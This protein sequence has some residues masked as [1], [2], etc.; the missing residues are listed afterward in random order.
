MQRRRFQHDLSVDTVQVLADRAARLRAFTLI[1]LLVVLAIIGVLFSLIGVGV[2]S[3]IGTARI[4]ATKGTI[5]KI[6]GLL[7][8]RMDAL[9]VKEPETALIDSLVPRFGNR[10]RAETM[11]R[12]FQFRQAFPQTWNEI[13]RFYPSLLTGHSYPASANRRAS[14]ESAEVLFFILTKANVLGYA[15]E[16]TDVFSSNEI[17]DTDSPPNGAI[18]FVDAWG[19]PLRFYRWPTRLIRG[20]AYASGGITPSPTARALI[21]SLPTTAADLTHDADDK[22]GLLQVNANWQQVFGSYQLP[23]AQIA[24]FENGLAPAPTSMNRSPFYQMGAFHTLET[25]SLPL[26]VSGGADQATGLYEP[27]DITNFGY[28]A[29]PIPAATNNTYDNVTNFNVRSGG[30]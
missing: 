3:A 18:E 14:T 1:E 11:A 13:E 30:K 24:Y 27:N 6:Q 15:P 16:G 20:A 7:Q 9:N 23:A 8:Q 26:I 25:M 29:Q 28:L 5:V 22:Y 12:K 21:P 4:A 2:M 10:K 19:Q 17:K